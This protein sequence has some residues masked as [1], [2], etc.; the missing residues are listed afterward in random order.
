MW[1]NLSTSSKEYFLCKD[2]VSSCRFMVITER[3]RERKKQWKKKKKEKIETIRAEIA[4]VC[5]R[6]VCFMAGFFY[7]YCFFFLLSKLRI[8]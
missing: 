6:F 3:R 1:E 4:S 5:I 2:P 7:G 8:L